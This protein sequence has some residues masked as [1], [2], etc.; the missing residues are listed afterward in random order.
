MRLW[1]LAA[2]VGCQPTDP[3][4]RLE[5]CGDAACLV[6]V[7]PAAWERDPD[8][9]WALVLSQG[10]PMTQAGLVA[11]IA[12]HHP[13]ALEE[14]C[15]DLPLGGTR[16]RCMRL[17]R[18]PHLRP[19]HQGRQRPHG[20]APRSAPGP[21]SAALPL[22]PAPVAVTPPDCGGAEASECA[23][24]AAERAVL[25]GRGAALE[26]ALGLCAL[27]DHGPDCVEHVL[28]L[29]VPGVPPADAASLA[30]LEEATAAA[31]R[32]REAAGDPLV[33]A[34]YEDWFWSVWAPTAYAAAQRLDG[35][36]LDALPP[37]A[38][39]QLRFALAW[40]MLRRDE[41]QREPELEGLEVRL[42]DLLAERPPLPPEP[43]PLQPASVVHSPDF[44]MGERRDERAIQASYC[45]GSMRRASSDDPTLDARLAL[46]EALA[47]QRPAPPA[48]P[49]LALVGSEE[50]ELIRWTGAR[51][52][53]V[54]DPE[55]AQALIP[56]VEAREPALV[57][58]RLRPRSRKD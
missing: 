56:S 25:E 32:A 54:L 53:G 47:R 13:G 2:L 23:F 33:G 1:L 6:E 10:D 12:S 42:R 52:G 35:R 58:E 19:A 38:Q 39:P 57:V 28:E 14:R 3:L 51:I 18:R 41:E 8:G 15:T 43:G 36:L 9:C 30:Q 55:A 21:G 34:L 7:L 11:A 44:W 17:T 4:Q 22:P 48:A 16:G 29:S 5:A 45:L 24:R 50:P 40:A 27:S 46:L 20:P 31:G 49:F 26:R 37:A